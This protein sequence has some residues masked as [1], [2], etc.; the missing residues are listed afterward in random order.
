[1]NRGNEAGSNS[2]RPDEAVMQ[3]SATHIDA[4]VL[5]VNVN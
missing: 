2:D 5:K 1:M 3:A 4:P